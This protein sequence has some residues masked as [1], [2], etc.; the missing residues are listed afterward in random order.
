MLEGAILVPSAFREGSWGLDLFS[1]F[2]QLFSFWLPGIV[3]LSVADV[4][5]A[6]LDSRCQRSVAV[7]YKT[8]GTC[9]TTPHE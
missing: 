8:D 2:L 3:L 5:S 4:G 7:R 1:S 9:C 6:G